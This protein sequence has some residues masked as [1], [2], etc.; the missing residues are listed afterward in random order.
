M[1]HNYMRQPSD[2][3]PKYKMP[4]PEG[5]KPEIK[6][7]SDGSIYVQYH[8]TIQGRHEVQM[9]FEGSGIDGSPFQCLVDSIDS[10]YVS[11]F[12]SGLVGG[13]SGENE[14]FTVVA[15]HGTLN[16]IQVTI[17]GPARTDVKRENKGDRAEF[18]YMPMTPGAY[19]INIKYKGKDIK[20]SPFQAKIS[21]EG[22]KRSQISIS[23]CSDY[24]L[25]VLEPEIVDLTGSLKKPSGA[26]EPC[27]LK[28]LAEGRLGI[29]SF[30]PKEKGNYAVNV[31][32][33]SEKHI[34]GS[35][36][37]IAVGDKEMAHASKV[38]VSGNLNSANANSENHIV[39]DTNGSGYGG[40]SV[41][42][43]GPHRT[44]LDFKELENRKYQVY[45]SPHEPGIY[46]LNIR[47]ADEH[48]N[49]SPFLLNVGGEP[50]GRVRETVTREMEQAE[51][52]MPKTKCEFLL[53][54]P[55]TNPFDM[56]ASITD[57]EGKTELCEVM[58]EDDF[59][60]RIN[61]TPQDKGNHIVSIKHKGMH[62]SGSPFQYTVGQ[63]KTGGS[64]KVQVGGPGVEKGEC[65]LWNTFNIYSREA[66][67]GTLS[68]AIEGPGKAMIKIEERPH[69]FLG[70]SYN[71]DKPG[72][73]GIHLKF[74]DEHIPDS[75]F[76]VTI[77][78][79]GGVARQ[80]TVHALKDRGLSIDKAATF[81]VSFNGAAG[82]LHAFI[83]SPSGGHDD[84]FIQ[85]MDTGVFG[86]RFIPKENGVHYVDVKLNDM[87]VPDS[88][89]A[90]MV[91]S[92]AADP[93]MVHAH[94]DGLETGNV[95][96]LNKFVVRTAGAGSGFLAAFID[97][98]SKVALSC[99]EVDEG[100][101][102]QYTPFCAGKYLITLK[103][104]NI[105]IA[106]SPYQAVI[107]GTGRK[108][109]PILEQSS[110]VVETVEKKP[111]MKASRRFRGDASKVVAS[112]PGI[113]KAF[114]NRAQNL[115][116]DVKEAGNAILFVGMITPN[117]TPESELVVKR[118]SNTSYTVTYT[119]KEAGEH[120]LQ[121][122]W[123]DDDIPGSPFCL[124]A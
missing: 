6:D 65:N 56:E 79:D 85:E 107:S 47:F 7:N 81:T 38:T 46:I 60:Y 117:G 20:G 83:R 87:H 42:M 100:Y 51:P 1:A 3:T 54:I 52:V 37:N 68:V 108:P 118:A 40:I 14:S 34:K 102:F 66:G 30:T 45:F 86:I 50:S 28:K 49:G 25:N 74:K 104:G 96:K 8:P 122:K 71:V 36:F 110:M 44:E 93:A 121:I 13:M 106:G 23:N 27:I 116:L 67:A 97:G 19:S 33:S 64:H 18:S 90:V 114:L 2:Q 92:V 48:V 21:G 39:I 59:H 103:Y 78:P 69:G 77:S 17:D 88:P 61:F 24:A 91:G 53:K 89:F 55:G 123:G 94:G 72:Q 120:L 9:S 98:P 124:H 119:C 76:K 70:V 4:T 12:G 31:H 105:G 73:Y 57:P 22:R 111:G 95:N 15:K 16:D 41:V 82:Q 29:A 112:G 63:L 109:S 75:P 80:V 58:D 113:K 101:E 115:T 84:C 32:T 43:E 5:L 11:I 99:K 62:I 35:P 10:G 26:I